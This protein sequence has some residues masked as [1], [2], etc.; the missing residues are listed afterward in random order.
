VTSIGTD[1]GRQLLQTLVMG[2]ATGPLRTAY[3]VSAGLVGF[4]FPFGLV[5][6]A[7]GL[8]PREFSWTATVIILLVSLTALFSEMRDGNVRSAA[9]RFGLLAPALFAVEWIGVHTGVPF[10]MYRYTHAL[11][12]LVCGVPLAIPFA[13]YATV[14]NSRYIARA[15]PGDGRRR[16]RAWTA[17]L[18][19][20][21]TVA[22]DLLLEPTASLV[23]EY[24]IWERA[25]APFENYL[26]WFLF[27]TAAVWWLEGS[28]AA[29]TG[30]RGARA[31]ALMLWTTQA[32]LFVLT[33]IIHGHVLPV[34][35][36]GGIILSC[37]ALII[38]FR[39]STTGAP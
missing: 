28:G 5:F 18:A 12:V 6:V 19:G 16:S 37:A 39:P 2:F 33:D 4:L 8:L 11:G 36:A 23:Q 32:A 15:L 21:L 25:V 14:V 9:I 34:L 31:T 10:G 22:L 1:R 24:W 3:L 17:L 13:W 20:V 29:R 38:L 30:E 35:L 7:G 27:S 26:S